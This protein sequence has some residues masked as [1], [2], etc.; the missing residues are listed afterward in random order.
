[1]CLIILANDISS[2]SLKDMETAYERNSQGFGV[3]YLNKKK[4]FISDKFVPKDFTEVKN[5]FNLH[6]EQ[7][8]RMA[9][10]FRLTTEGATN[11]KNCHPFISYKS[12]NRII[13]LMHNGARLPVKLTHKK[14]SDT[15]HYNQYI[16][17]P[18]FSKNP[19]KVLETKF[20]TELEKHIV[21]DKM[22]F[23]DSK[24][25]KFI[26]INE[27]LGNYKGANWF[28]ND[29]WNIPKFNFNSKINLYGNS[30]SYN[31][32]DAPTDDELLNMTEQD[33]YDFV[34]NC[35]ENYNFDAI[36]EIIQDYK[37]LLQQKR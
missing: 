15:W 13:G 23:L 33:I 1:M 3:M 22:I 9:I 35:Y 16:L 30:L 24:S 31:Y 34:Y 12:D 6:K 18:V 36:V 5:F 4:E 8:D 25:Q 11:K 17:K 26:I 29:Y 20:K 21:S 27:N 37:L 10:H 7:T 14:C 28:S 2:V 32:L 19:N